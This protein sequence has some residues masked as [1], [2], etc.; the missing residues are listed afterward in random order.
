[1]WRLELVLAFVTLLGLALGLWG[2]VWHR[3]AELQRRA[4]LGGNLFLAALLS[5]GACAVFAAFHRCEGLVPLGLTAGFL[6]VGMMW[7]APQNA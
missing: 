3:G 7:E 6:V 5:L 2:L 4:R 1:M